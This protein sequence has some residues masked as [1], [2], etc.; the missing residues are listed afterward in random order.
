LNYR[1]DLPREIAEFSVQKIEEYNQ[2]GDDNKACLLRTALLKHD[3]LRSTMAARRAFVGLVEGEITFAPTFKFDKNSDEFDTSHK[4]RIP[5]WTDRILFK[6]FGT[7]VIEY[8]SVPNA[9]HSD[10]RPVFATFRVNTE[11]RP[12]SAK[13]TRKRPTK[14]LPTRGFKEKHKKHQSKRKI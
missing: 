3:Q 4:Q 5:A 13:S 2:K 8:K 11:G 14:S 7:R 10:H 6:P 12:E 1:L 9:R